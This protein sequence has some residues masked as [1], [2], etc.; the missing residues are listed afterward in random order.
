MRKRFS[1][2]AFIVLVY[3]LHDSISIAASTKTPFPNDE[4]TEK[5]IRR[6]KIEEEARQLEKNGLY[7][8]AIEK[9]RE[10][11]DPSLLNYDYEAGVALGGIERIYEKQ[12]KY[13]KSLQ[14]LKWHLERNPEKYE[15]QKRR[16]EALIQARDTESSQPL[17]DHIAYLKEKY[18]KQLPPSYGVPWEAVVVAIIRLYDHIGDM[19]A[20]MAF[21][22]TFISYY[23]KKSGIKPEQIGAKNQYLIIKQAFE[24]D[25]SEGFKGCVDA[26]PGDAC[27]GRA[28]KA[29]I[30][31]NYFPW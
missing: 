21:M 18:K 27:M 14:K 4:G 3:M 1:S 25:K 6:S 8:Q 2:I 5:I 23:A 31:S 7:D 29:L 22:D 17:Y 19:D 12:N 16:L 9:Y 24:Q 26:K 10:A 20:G 11:T 13:E 15:D 28:T 30:Q